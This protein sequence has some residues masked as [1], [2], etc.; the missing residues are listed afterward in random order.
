MGRYELT[1]RFRGRERDYIVREDQSLC[2]S[3]E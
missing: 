1:V 3:R 2:Q